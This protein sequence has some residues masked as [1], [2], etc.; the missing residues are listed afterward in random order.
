MVH[1]GLP[2]EKAGRPLVR[3]NP[4]TVS[5]PDKSDDSDGDGF[6][7]IGDR[8]KRRRNM[9]DQPYAEEEEEVEVI[10]MEHDGVLVR[11]RDH[12]YPTSFEEL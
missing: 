9:D 10:H 5:V 3:L 11:E 1:L 12:P 8:P 7:R 4:Q 6:G 2:L